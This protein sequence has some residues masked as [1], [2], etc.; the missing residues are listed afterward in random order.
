MSIESSCIAAQVLEGAG[1][2]RFPTPFV[3]GFG[4]DDSGELIFPDRPE[5]HHEPAEHLA[6]SCALL[7]MTPLPMSCLLCCPPHFKRALV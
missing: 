6:L 1:V 3:E 7:H 2:Q 4:W 5:V